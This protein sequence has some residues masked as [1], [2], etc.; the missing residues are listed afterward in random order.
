MAPRRLT[1]TT[2][3]FGVGGGVV[4]A[5]AALPIAKASKSENRA[6]LFTLVLYSVALTKSA[7]IPYAVAY[8]PGFSSVIA[9]PGKISVSK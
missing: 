4:C 3:P 7:S 6:A 9:R 1:I 8:N 5:D 2:S